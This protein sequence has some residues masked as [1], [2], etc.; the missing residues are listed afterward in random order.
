LATT[1]VDLQVVGDAAETASPSLF[2]AQA[3]IVDP[4]LTPLQQLACNILASVINATGP[5]LL[6][7]FVEPRKFTVEEVIIALATNSFDGRQI[8]GNGADGT[9]ASPDG[10]PGGWIFGNGGNGYTPP[11]GSGLVGGNGG[12][13]GLFGNGGNG[14]A[15]AA[16]QNGEGGATGGNGGA[17]Q[18]F[19][20]GGT[21]G[22]GGAAG[23]GIGGIGG[24]G[25]AG[26]LL[27]GGG[28]TGGRGGDGASGCIG[29]AGGA[30]LSFGLGYF[31]SEG[32]HPGQIAGGTGGAGGTGTTGTGGTG[33]V[34]GASVVLAIDLTDTAL[35][36]VTQ[37][38]GVADEPAVAIGGTGGRGGDGYLLGGT[39]GAGGLGVNLMSPGYSIKGTAVGGAGGAGGDASGILSLVGVGGVG[40]PGG[41][42]YSVALD[43][44]H[45]SVGGKGG[46]G[47][48]GLAIDGLPGAGIGLPLV[49]ATA[50][51]DCVIR[52]CVAP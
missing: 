23:P 36:A 33:G 51:V 21:G 18:L 20:S 52:L 13:A 46:K 10:Q 47:L 3:I 49:D 39:G 50:V 12:A 17:A 19:G 30:V 35:R 7:L 4:T 44:A 6:N 29:G 9:A 5:T 48:L 2:A 45:L 31:D 25:G 15:G 24:I 43:S 14:G 41:D 34:G 22:A 26:G 16:G 40:G 27:S 42:S 32:Y 1:A 28:G 8:V 38:T 11:A 37:F